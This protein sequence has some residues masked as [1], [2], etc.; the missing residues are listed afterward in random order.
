MQGIIAL[1]TEG[2]DAQSG[3]W[4]QW[5]IFP[6]SC[7]GPS[8]LSTTNGRPQHEETHILNKTRTSENL[9]TYTFLQML[10]TSMF[11]TIFIYLIVKMH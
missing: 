7:W 3:N 6:V 5:N 9:K 10:E 1:I 8:V 4:M 2:L 11:C